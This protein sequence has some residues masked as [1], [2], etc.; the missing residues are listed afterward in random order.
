MVYHIIIQKVDN[1][2]NKQ[3][4]AL[5]LCT[6]FSIFQIKWMYS[7]VDAMTIINNYS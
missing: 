3:D 1:T 5:A 7:P 6:N 2:N 4:L